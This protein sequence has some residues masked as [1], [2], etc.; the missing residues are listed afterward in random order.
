MA[1]GGIRLLVAALLLTALPVSGFAQEATLAGT[2]SDSSGAV[3]P[4]VAIRAVHEATG[5]TIENVTDDRGSYRL[6]ARIGSYRITAVLSG[7]ATVTRTGVELSVGQTF[8]LNLVMSIS[9][10]EE[11]VTVEAGAPLIDT[12]SSRPSGVVSKLQMEEIP[13]NGRNF[14][15]LTVLAPGSQANAVSNMG[16]ETRNNRGDYQLNVDGQQLT[17]PVLQFRL[18]PTFSRDAIAEF[19][20]LANRFD[21]TQGRSIGVV[22]NVIT[23]SG[24]NTP[25]GSF[26]GY[27]RSDRFN[28]ADFI[29]KRVLPYS[30][31]QISGTFGGPIVRNKLHFFASYEG[32]R[33]PNVITS[34]SRWPSFNV[35]QPFTRVE[36]KALGRVDYQFSP[37]TRLSVRLSKTDALP[38]N[39]GGGALRHP[40]T[41]ITYQR[42]SLS[43]V[44]T[45][46]QVFGSHAVNEIKGGYQD[47]HDVQNQLISDPANQAKYPS[48]LGG[49]R[50]PGFGFTGGYRIGSNGAVPSLFT[51]QTY[52]LRD[53]V[54]LTVQKGRGSHA[55][56]TGGELLV[57]WVSAG[58]CNNCNGF[59]D[60]TGGAV[61][62][63]LEQLFP[64]YND[65]TTWNVNALLPLVRS[66]SWQ[67]GNIEQG[68][69]RP[70]VAAWLQDDWAITTKLTLNLGIRYDVSHNQF[71]NETEIPSCSRPGCTT[72]PFLV[73]NRPSDK[74]NV[75][76][77]FGF[78]YSLNDRTVVRGGAGKFYSIA[79]S[80]VGTQV[81]QAVN[82]AEVFVPFDG[83]PDFITNPLNGPVPTYEQVI[84]DP[85]RERSILDTIS[86]PRYQEPEAYQGSIGFERQFGPALAFSSDFLAYEARGEG[87]R[88]FF[89]RNINLQYNPATGTNYPS[90][91]KSHRNWPDWG[92]IVQEQYGFKTS[93]RALDLTLEKRMRN[94]WMLGG[95]YT[96]NF[97][98]DYQPPP[99]VG[100]PLALDYGG[101]WTYAVLDQRHRAVFNGIWQMGHGFELSGLYFYGSGQR[102]ATTWGGGDLRQEGFVSTNRV[103]SNGTIVPRNNFVGRPI[104]R[105][106][107]RFTKR[108]T[109]GRVKLDGVWELFNVFNHENYG[110]YVT[111]ESNA[112]YGQPTANTNVAYQPRMMQLG[113]KVAF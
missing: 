41:T 47:S 57:N 105:V 77:R 112:Q 33:E 64:V 42:H 61:P 1:I 65:T 95:T 99:D 60:V 98:K 32:E 5:N 22:L 84:N 53:Q 43:S 50:L 79:S 96:L 15:D 71:A 63:N 39:Q 9:S 76:P 7:F 69:W 108:V 74:N 70:D 25:A 110:S 56:R 48:S 23:K 6:P 93:R 113:F 28:A 19:E 80:N 111:A 104:H 62:A 29:Q 86:V 89:N 26:A 4:G 88:G 17:S 54:T 68:L 45:L 34:S 52:S 30:N 85:G 72:P 94:R 3:L 36:L 97:T 87:G 75:A 8:V 44:A 107:L 51:G 13:V 78:V 46:T 102:F 21:A 31:Q 103:R 18:N 81:L 92:P 20:L 91:D 73:G 16:V 11:S 59:F 66:F 2:I 27:F 24:T 35:D 10:L 67:V 101:E 106:D 83:R 55:I 12:T 40:S 82:I 14:L 49:N 90:S 109:L 58:S 38:F 37:Q 100:F